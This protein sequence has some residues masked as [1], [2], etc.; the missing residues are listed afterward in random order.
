MD[1]FP[2]GKAGYSPAKRR[3]LNMTPGPFLHLHDRLRYS[4]FVM[5]QFP[6]HANPLMTEAPC[7]QASLPTRLQET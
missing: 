6:P 3:E 4:G 5:P 7:R 2:D 1:A